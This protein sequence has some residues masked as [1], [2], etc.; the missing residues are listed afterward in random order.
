MRDSRARNKTRPHRTRTRPP[1]PPRPAPTAAAVKAFL[2]QAGELQ[3]WDD[4]YLRDMLGV[5]EPEAGR[6]LAILE[7]TGYIERASGGWRNTAAG[8]RMA[9]VSN[10]K[11]VKRETIR[12]QL[13]AL[14]DRVREVNAS[15]RFL[16]R[17]ERVT[18]FGPYLN[19]SIEQVKNADLAIELAPKETDP[20][21]REALE[22]AR[23]DEAAASGKRFQS[24]QQRH[25]YPRNEVLDFIKGRSRAIALYDVQPWLQRR[26]HTVIFEA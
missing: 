1:A 9:G 24:Y 16:Y 20:Q 13:G 23:I 11:P 5:D 2:L 15:D 18:L 22:A 14:L 17:V 10:A 8:N 4:R 19:H 26:P 21:K 3:S 7:A 6:I 25:E 12:K